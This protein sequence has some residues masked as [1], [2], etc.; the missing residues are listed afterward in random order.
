MKLKPGQMYQITKK[1]KIH[2]KPQREV[3][4]TQLGRFAKETEHTYRFSGFSVNKANV[5]EITSAN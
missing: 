1:I 2:T 4:V 3:L 5:V